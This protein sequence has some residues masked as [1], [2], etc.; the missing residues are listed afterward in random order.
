MNDLKLSLKMITNHGDVVVQNINVIKQYSMETSSLLLKTGEAGA[1]AARKLEGVGSVANT[2]G[3]RLS[4]L[5][6]NLLG[7]RNV[8]KDLMID[9]I[10]MSLVNAQQDVE[11][12]LLRTESVVRSLGNTAGLSV[13]ELVDQASKVSASTSYGRDEVLLAQDAV[14]KYSNVS[15]EAFGDVIRLSADL[16]SAMGV[17]LPESAKLLGEALSNPAEGIKL[18]AESGFDFSE[19]QKTL[20]SELSD[21]GK[22]LEVQAGVIGELR[23]QIGGLAGSELTELERSQK[24]YELALNTSKAAIADYLGLS[25]GMAD[26]YSN[27]SMA[28]N[29]VNEAFQSGELDRYISLL[30]T[31]TKV[32][33][34]FA[35]AIYGVPAV[36]GQAKKAMDGLSAALEYKSVVADAFSQ[37]NAL[38]VKSL[39][40]L[41]SAT[42]LAAAAY[43]GW[44]IGTYLRNEFEVVEKAG[45][46]LAAGIHRTAIQIEGYFNLL[47]EDIKFAFSNPLDY[48]QS[49]IID[50]FKWLSSL[51]GKALGVLGLDGIFSELDGK[52][53]GLKSQT[54]KQHE[55]ALKKISEATANKLSEVDDSYSS[56]FANVGKVVNDTEEQVKKLNNAIN[57]AP[58]SDLGA[59]AINGVT[60]AVTGLVTA[61]ENLNRSDAES[62]NAVIDANSRIDATNEYK[63]AIEQ[64]LISKEKAKEVDPDLTYLES[65]QRETEL[66]QIKLEKSQQE[67]EVQK[68]LKQLKGD[69]PAMQAAIESQ[70][71]AQQEL[72]NQISKSGEA[73]SKPFQDLLDSLAKLEKLGGSAGSGIF[74]SFGKV[75]T[76]LGV[77]TGAQKKYRE[78]LGK[79]Q[80]KREE[81]EALDDGSPAAK[82]KIIAL[83]KEE[84]KLKL[85]NLQNTAGQ[86]SALSGT[87]SKF[88]GEQSREREALHK[89]EMAFS[90]V[91][92]AITIQKAAQNALVAITTQGQGDPYTAFA[93]IA[94]MAALMASLGAFS[95]SANG[96]APTSAERQKK[97]GTGTLLGDSSAKSNSIG[98]VFERIEELELD[99]YNELR[100][101][102]TSIKALNAGIAKLAVN[103]VS[104]YGRF[105]E[106][107][108]KG[109]LGRS[110]N[111]STNG[112]FEKIGTYGTQLFDPLLGTALTNTLGDPLGG[113]IDSIVGSFSTTKRKL[114]DSGISFDTQSIGEILATGIV[115]ASYYS[116]IE[117]TKKKAWGLSKKKS[118]STD[119]ADL[120][121]SLLEEFGRVFTHIGTSVNGAVEVLGLDL[122]RELKNYVINLPHLS[123][124]D[125][126]GDE[127]EKELSAVFSSQSDLMVKWL[128]PAMSQYQKMGEGLYETLIRVAQ[129]QAIVN[130]QL[131]TL[132]IQISAL[133]DVTAETRIAVSQSLIE[134]MGG[135]EEFRDLTSEYFDGFYSDAEKFANLSGNV[136]SAFSDLGLTLPE[137]ATGIRGIVDAIDLTTDSGRQLFSTLMQLVPSLREYY[138]IVERREEFEANIRGELASLD[139]SDFE[140]SVLDLQGW[141]NEQ[142][143]IAESV[144]AE[145]VFIERLYARKRVDA[146]ESE[147]TRLNDEHTRS[148]EGLNNQYQQVYS[149]IANASRGISDAILSI[150]RQSGGWNEVSYQQSQIGSLKGQIG[151]GSTSDQISAIQQMQ[152]AIT[153]RYNAEIARNKQLSDAAQQRYQAELAAV[154]AIRSAAQQLLNAADSM[155]ISNLSPELLGTRMGEAKKQFDGL[156][157]AAGKGDA[158]AMQQL[159]SMG[160]SYL[161]IAKEFYAQGSTE[162]AAI[163]NQIHSTYRSIGASAPE[164]PRAPAT[165]VAYQNSDT[166]LQQ[167]ALRELEALQKKLEE[168]QE[169]EKEEQAAATA[170]LEA[171]HRQARD[172]A[173]ATQNRHIEA[174]LQTG[175]NIVA[176]LAVQTRATDAVIVELRQQRDSANTDTETL[177]TELARTRMELARTQD[178][179][180]SG[181][182]VM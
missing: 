68:A 38:T 158:S 12:N 86:Y 105:N 104:T 67:Y 100:S 170:A 78:D 76:Q 141:Y 40:S 31:S 137:S 65:L 63:N 15:G 41:R 112:F 30:E 62:N 8:A 159:Q 147:M 94:A 6:S 157:A 43:A 116:V 124:K 49:K 73:S 27:L 87:M 166:Y 106:S 80:K 57:L 115:E 178:L 98:N 103:L 1:E 10:F 131:D 119:Y 48:A 61:Q 175:D 148:L 179:V 95:G 126:S 160:G 97:Q 135:I 35:F 150:R 85:D 44:E 168:L 181:R 11:K 26:I 83:E 154:N 22:L 82:K 77:M 70:I 125:L 51:G 84:S 59:T 45:I 111:S 66:L 33:G 88:F 122:E 5:G 14:L 121:N 182:R 167:S 58:G 46:A 92:I 146:I 47:S 139:M 20:W 21:N 109:Q 50:F 75:T 37:R 171:E 4:G 52:L 90:A 72:N 102:N 42:L 24:Q 16:A 176:A 162:Y 165:T 81:L 93:R 136:N 129:E 156:A 39:F 127:I 34:A 64:L 96:S 153:A 2:L 79:L 17:S 133:G 99:Q 29:T 89:M 163:F 69:D 155:L 56:A 180:F 149:A 55:D 152:Q 53:D 120:D 164:E 91:E 144:G 174:T 142:I 177:R 172:E 123:L 28:L 7:I 113:L 108:Y 110:N 130:A 118:S 32:V 19:S 128:V 18:L 23:E 71:K 169:K 36:A 140:Q 107:S 138:D 145:T 134:L 13:K 9:E 161:D 143:R 117:T 132:G 74:E 114:T 25:D 60:N 101:I 3:S 54:V 151:V 173:L